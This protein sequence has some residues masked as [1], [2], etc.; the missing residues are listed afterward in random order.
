MRLGFAL[1]VLGQPGLKSHDSRRWQNEP[2]L[3]VSLAY[4]RDVFG[5]LRRQKVRMYRLSAELAPYVTHPD[6]PQ[7][8]GQIDECAVELASVGRL[9]RADGLRLSFHAPA[10]AVLN[11]LDESVAAKAAAD[12]N[13]LARLLDSLEQGPEAVV[14]LHVGGVYGDRQAASRRFV[15][16]YHALPAAARRRLA[17]EHDDD[18]FS[19]ADVVW[20]HDHTGIPLVYDHLHHRCHNPEKLNTI[21]ALSLCLRSWPDGVRPKVHFS[22]PRTAMRVVERQHPTTGARV[23]FLHPPQP[24]EHAD[25]VHPFEFIAFLRAARQ[26]GLP[27]FD[28]MLEVRAKDLALLRLRQDVARF[29]PELSQDVA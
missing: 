26:A 16:R 5:Y 8:Q 7:F 15:E 25:F 4:L 12:L 23:R 3:S 21:E 18:R 19:V 27:D 28:V 17:L 29:A 14:V 22:S 1:K 9:A 2:H 6:M 13:A 11:A 24:T 20:I 10:T